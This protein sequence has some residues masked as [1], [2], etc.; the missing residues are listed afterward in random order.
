MWTAEPKPNSQPAATSRRSRTSFI[1]TPPCWSWR[2]ELLAGLHGRHDDRVLLLVVRHAEGA[3]ALGL[4]VRV[5]ADVD[6]R[7]RVGPTVLH[8]GA[9]V[10]ARHGGLVVD[11][12]RL[13]DGVADL[14]VLAADVPG[15]HPHLAGFALAAQQPLVTGRLVDR[16]DE[17]SRGTR[18]AL[19]DAALEELV[20]GREVADGEAAGL[21]AQLG[22]IPALGER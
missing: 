8:L 9:A 3:V 6:T 18:I 21:V 15:R 13:D 19:L 16:V 22:P 17:R 11:V 14:D 4:D 1:A 20:I 10:R 5:D 12:Q 7:C 2:Q